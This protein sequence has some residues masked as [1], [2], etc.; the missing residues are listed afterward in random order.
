MDQKAIGRRLR[1]LRDKRGYSAR[2]VAKKIGLN[3][4]YLWQL[5]EG[6]EAFRTLLLLELARAL[7]VPPVYFFV[8]DP[9]I[10]LPRLAEKLAKRGFAPTEGLRSAMTNPEFLEFLEWCSS[11]AKYQT[12]NVDR[13]EEALKRAKRRAKR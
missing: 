3:H 13:L 12:K 9:D 1:E 7:E 6:R 8:D 10:P 11:A 2:E 5:E 4:R